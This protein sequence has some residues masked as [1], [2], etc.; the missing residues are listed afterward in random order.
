MYYSKFGNTHWVVLP[1]TRTWMSQAIGVLF[2]CLGNICRSPMAEAVFRHLVAARELSGRLQIDS[3][4]IGDWHAGNAPHPGTLRALGAH[5]I[6][7]YRHSARQVRRDDFQTFQY[8]VAMD[9]T[10]L[11][12]LQRLMREPRAEVRL[13]MD[14][15][16]QAGQRDVPDP[17][18]SHRF[19]E[20][21]QLVEQGCR[22]LL[23][24][25]I[26]REGL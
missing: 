24:H 4:G 13:L 21:Y 18:Y 3:A 15:A 26:R 8:I 12:D 14:Y 20:V 23:D 5:G 1:D 6:T 17:Y 10:N 11:A 2:V 22:G 7:N 25:I 19:E 9:S 16:P